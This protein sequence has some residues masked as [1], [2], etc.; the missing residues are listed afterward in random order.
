MIELVWKDLVV[1]RWFLVFGL[2]LYALQLALTASQA[3]VF[4]IFTTVFSG[5][6]G[7]GSIG[8]EDRQNTE[9]LWCSLPVTRREVVLARYLSTGLGLLLGLGLSWSIGRVAARLMGAAAD[10]DASVPTGLLAYAALFALLALLA[11]VFL[12]CYF[13]FGAGKGLVVFSAVAVGVL[14]V[15]PLLLHLALLLAGYGN[16]LMDPEVWR[17]GAEKLRAEEGAR[18]A[19]RVVG[20]M[21]V[22]ACGAVLLS[23]GL[24]IRFFEKRDL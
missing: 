23:A 22:L 18:L 17:R 21:A 1:A 16:P 9:S 7:F 8:L 6:L 24:S 4:F 20:G 19:Q 14:I 11:E 12:P 13:R 3:P 5:L 15:A 2:P 10:G